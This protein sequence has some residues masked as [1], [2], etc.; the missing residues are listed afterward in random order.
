MECNVG[1][2]DKI[3]RLFI[4]LILIAIAYFYKESIG[5]WIWLFYIIAII[6]LITV[7][8]SFCLPYKLLGVNTC[9]KEEKPV[10]PTKRKRR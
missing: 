8:I 3:I 10:K 2:K 7:L 5:N 4:A 9:G 1:K 6:M